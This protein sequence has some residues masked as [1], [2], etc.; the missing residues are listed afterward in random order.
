MISSQWKQKKKPKKKNK[1]KEQ[2]E[3]SSKIS[4]GN[5][6]KSGILLHT[7]RAYV[8]VCVCAC[9]WCMIELWKVEHIQ[10]LPFP[11]QCA[12]LS[13]FL[14]WNWHCLSSHHLLHCPRNNENAPYKQL[15]VYVC[16]RLRECNTCRPCTYTI[17]DIFVSS[18]H[19]NPCSKLG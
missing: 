19:N 6:Q 17:H 1:K 10:T 14:R 2:C 9:M 16:V 12:P 11:S 7:Y 18:A 15:I 3:I 4:T 8:C 13:H 5:I